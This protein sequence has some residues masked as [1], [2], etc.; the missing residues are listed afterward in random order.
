MKER[1]WST[2]SRAEFATKKLTRSKD[3]FDEE[4][5]SWRTPGNPSAAWGS[6]LEARGFLLI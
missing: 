6:S 3:G 2:V 5:G 4:E 1:A